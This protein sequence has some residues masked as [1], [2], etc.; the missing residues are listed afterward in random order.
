MRDGRQFL[1][2]AGCLAVAACQ[3]TAPQTQSPQPQ[4]QPQPHAGTIP[5]LLAR[6]PPEITY[7]GGDGA[8]QDAA[9]RIQGAPNDALAT[10]AEYAWLAKHFPG[11]KRKTQALVQAPHGRFFDMIEIE[12]A[13]G[14]RRNFYFDISDTFGKH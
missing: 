4:P 13:T 12:L 10:R 8:T 1:L 11:F 7:A 5:P 9:I 3:T 6:P 2:L 14:E